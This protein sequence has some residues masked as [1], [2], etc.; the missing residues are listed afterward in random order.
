MTSECTAINCLAIYLRIRF[1]KYFAAPL[2][3]S[4]FK[5]KKAESD[6]EQK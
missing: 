1:K 2:F 5:V 3:L 4:E 6:H